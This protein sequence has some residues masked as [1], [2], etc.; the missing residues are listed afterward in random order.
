M[1]LFLKMVILVVFKWLKIAKV[2]PFLRQKGPF[3]PT[4][5]IKK[6]FYISSVNFLWQG[7]PPQVFLTLLSSIFLDCEEF[8]AAETYKFEIF[9]STELLIYMQIYFYSPVFLHQLDFLLIF[10]WVMK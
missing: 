5:A 6:A 2:Q 3:I 1:V 10:L 8:L 4:I 9:L 7:S